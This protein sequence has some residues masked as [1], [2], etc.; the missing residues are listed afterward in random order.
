MSDETRPPS[1]GDFVTMQEAAELLGVSR[2]QVAAI[3]KRLNL[4]VYESQVD[5]RR[6]LIRRTD[7]E[8]AAQPR[9]K[10]DAA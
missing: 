2:F 1:R 8:A 7:V 9:P 4:R 3:V 5:R 6:K 10:T